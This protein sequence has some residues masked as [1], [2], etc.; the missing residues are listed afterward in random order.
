MVSSIRTVA[1]PNA[2][3]VVRKGKQALKLLQLSILVF[4][5]GAR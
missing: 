2:L 1:N 5:G 3:F 4:Y